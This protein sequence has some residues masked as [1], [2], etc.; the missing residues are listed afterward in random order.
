MSQVQAFII[1]NWHHIQKSAERDLREQSFH[2]YSIYNSW[3]VFLSYLNDSCRISAYFG[4]FL[5]SSKVS[6]VQA[7]IIHNWHHIQKSVEQKLR[8]QLLLFHSICNSLQWS[9][10]HLN[11][12]C[13][14]SAYFGPFLSSSEESQ[15]QAFIIHNRHHIQQSAEHHL[16]EQFLLFHSIYKN[17]LCS[18]PHLNDSCR[19]SA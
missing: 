5:S 2:F 9:F 18:F 8:K 12:S 13:R 6:Q 19:I 7:F 1:H 10:P 3:L 4:P 15:V 11:D 14:V 16:R 17:L